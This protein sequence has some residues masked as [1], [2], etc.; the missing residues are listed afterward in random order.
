METYK[1]IHFGADYYPE[2]WP[3]ERLREDAVLMQE[4]GIQLVRLAEFSWHRLEPEEGKY[5]FGW[6]DEAVSVLGEHG[7]SVILGTPTAAPPAWLINKHPEILPIDRQ[8]RRRSF[9][10]RHHD[11]QSNPVYRKLVRGI[12]TAM[13]EHFAEN[14]HVI[15]WQTDNELGN[16][17]GDLCIC[18]SCRKSFQ[19][20]L[21]KKYGSIEALNQA[22]G[23]AFWSQE[24]NSFQEIFAPGITVAGE[25]PSEMLDWKCF[26]SD[27]IVDFQKE[28]IEILRKYCPGH[29]ITHNCMGFADKVNY[30]DLTRPLDF[31]SHDQYPGGFYGKMPWESPVLMAANLDMTRGFKRQSF[32][33]MEQQAGPTGWEI[34][35]RTPAPGQLA[36]WTGQ[37]IAHGADAVVF[38]RW[39]TC[40]VGTE[41]YWHGILPHSGRPGR[42]YAELKEMTKRLSPFMD[43]LS[44]SI[45]RASAAIVFSYRQEY[46]LQIQPHHP[47]L[48]YREQVLK[49][50]EALYRRNIPVDFVEE[51]SDLS[52]YKLVL[53]PLQYLM[54]P[55][56][57]RKYTEYVAAGGTLVLTMRSGVKDEHNICVSDR[58]L[59]GALGELCGMEILDYDCLRDV[60]VRVD[61]EGREYSAGKWSDII[62]PKTAETLAVYSSEFYASAPCVTKNIYGAGRVFYIGTEPEEELLFALTDRIL[63]EAGVK[64]LGSA[65]KG[66]ELCVREKDGISWVFAVNLTRERASYQLLNTQ[67]LSL[68]LGEKEGLLEPFEMHLYRGRLEEYGEAEQDCCVD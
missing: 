28:Q 59:P 40:T 45:P 65:D 33:I 68:E 36:A 53:A 44:G 9:G 43:E 1:K 42:R 11:C 34:L 12:V 15:G 19:Q 52:G 37:S 31:A 63:K 32:W 3:L 14:P 25:N 24:Y 57:V 13:A 17:H 27:L 41:Q 66:V 22:W 50:Y 49:Y 67:G 39:R 46:A 64:G 55:E 5:E 26:C 18:P 2:H 56:L 62:T 21:E 23:T 16:S 35:G 60:K 6:L 20:W 38:F 8:G 4:M 30:Y 61:F 7:I 58:E 29:L 51:G 48:D 47:E 10:G 54:Y